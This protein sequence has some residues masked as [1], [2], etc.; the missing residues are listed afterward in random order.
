M[1]LHLTG[2][3]ALVTGASRGIGLATIHALE[4]EG[5]RVVAADRSISPELSATGAITINADL[6][7]QNAAHKLVSQT[8]SKLGGLDILINNLG[9]GD[10]LQGGLLDFDEEQWHRTFEL[11]FFAT[12]RTT[13]AAI[14]T[15]IDTGG[16][17]V[18]VSSLGAK[19]PVGNPL[20]YTSSKA[21]LDA[22]GKGVS[23]EFGPQ[24]VRVKTVSPGPVR[25][26]LRRSSDGQNTRLAESLG[27]SHDALLNEIPVKLGLTTG[28][29]VEAHEVAA[30]I[31][32]L[33][34]SVADSVVGSDHL[35]EGGAL[36]TV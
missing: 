17:I 18:N 2:K 29:L 28:R 14:P 32:Y 16:V 20:P 7:Q 22:F 34:S 6:S 5:V 23:E 35:I 4:A 8:V 24:G 19:A 36:K 10:S 11:N 21:A 12:V 30:L 1:D 27:A 33:T 13:R 25:E 9:G 15:L 26:A 3:S 31:T